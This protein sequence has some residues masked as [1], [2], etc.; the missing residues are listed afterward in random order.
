VGLLS[1]A[2]RKLL[3][4]GDMF[5]SVADD[6][7]MDQASRMSRMLDQGFDP[8]PLY[9]GTDQPI[10]AFR[11]SDGWYGNGVYASRSPKQA[12]YYTRRT[13]AQAKGGQDNAPNIMPL[14]ARGRFASADEYHALVSQNMPRG[15]WSKAAEDNAV[16]KAQQEL[17]GRG[18]AGIDAGGPDEEVVIFDPSN[19]RSRFAAFDPAKAGSS[20]LL[21]GIGGGALTGGGLLSRAQRERQSA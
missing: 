13:A 18:Y 14:V 2:A 8:A 16:R 4:S 12:E 15:Q 1:K 3:E 7:P 20:D 21:A 17:Q 9:H 10:D 11:A 19:V 6:L 5:G